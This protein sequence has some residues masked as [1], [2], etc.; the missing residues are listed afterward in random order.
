[1]PCISIAIYPENKNNIDTSRPGAADGIR[2]FAEIRC[3]QKRLGRARWR[4]GS[5]GL[6]AAHIGF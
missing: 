3:A 1:M 5:P 6:G 4:A 2:Q